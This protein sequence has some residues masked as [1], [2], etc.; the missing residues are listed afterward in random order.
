[1]HGPRLGIA[2]IIGVSLAGAMLN[3]SNAIAQAAAGDEDPNNWPL[4]HRTNNG[5]R[6]S[7]LDQINKDNVGHLH[8]AWIH[9]GGDPAGGMQE[10]PIVIDGVIYSMTAGSRVAA[11][12]ARTG[13]EIWHHEIKLNPLTGKLPVPPFNRGVTVGRGKV[14]VSMIDGRA[15]ALNQQTGEQIWATQ[16][17]D[18]NKDC[19]SCILPS[20]P[21]LADD[22]LIFG[23]A[24]AE[25]ASAGKIYGVN[26]DTG[27]TQWQ[28]DTIKKAR[29]AGRPQ[30]LSV[31]AAAARGCPVP[32]MPPPTRSSTALPIRPRTF[33]ARTERATIFTP[34]PCSLSSPR[35]AG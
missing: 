15:I 18:Y 21:V 24:V 9:H 34:T 4:Y 16:L 25:I 5:W 6:Y 22:I 31:M 1:M 29:K 14:F 28:F 3:C 26:A 23:S 13:K 27:K 20:P 32:T 30:K 10:T 7:P 33:G 19:A 8:V 12:D 11:I 35:P 2:L 17:T